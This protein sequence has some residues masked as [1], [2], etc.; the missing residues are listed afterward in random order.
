MTAFDQVAGAVQPG[1][2]GVSPHGVS[3]RSRTLREVDDRDVVA[4]G[5]E[6]FVD[7]GN[8]CRGDDP[9]DRCR[10]E[11][12]YRPLGFALPAPGLEPDVHLGMHQGLPEFPG[13]VA[14]TREDL[15]TA[16]DEL[17][18]G[19]HADGPRTPGPQT[20]G[21]S[22]RSVFELLDRGGDPPAGLVTD[23]S[24]AREVARD[25]LRR[26]TRGPTDVGHAGPARQASLRRLR[27]RPRS[28]SVRRPCRPHR[29]QSL[30]SS[31]RDLGFSRFLHDPLV[32][33][34]SHVTVGDR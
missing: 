34:R 13:S 8:R 29:A 32:G 31:P 26:D 12:V 21:G 14:E 27:G 11:V 22:I 4:G 19:Q 2:V 1:S 24:G 23:V 17:P 6:R 33:D 10:E 20:G 9:V 3:D 18:Y 25:G 28:S 15:G 7:T 30:P 5:V 16:M